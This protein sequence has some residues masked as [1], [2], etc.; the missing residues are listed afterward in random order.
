MKADDSGDARIST[1]NAF[2]GRTPSWDDE[3]DDSSDEVD[4][5]GDS[6]PAGMDGGDHELD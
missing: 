2:P 6:S 4:K 5:D 1:S 3:D